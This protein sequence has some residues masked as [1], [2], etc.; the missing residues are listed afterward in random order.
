ML[1]VWK[2][3]A[4]SDP[5]NFS[6]LVDPV[7]EQIN[8]FQLLGPNTGDWLIVG[9][10]ITMSIGQYRLLSFK[11]DHFFKMNQYIYTYINV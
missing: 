2:P 9:T 10:Y 3:P 6:D 4:M 5:A 1:V 11:R 7:E 8:Q